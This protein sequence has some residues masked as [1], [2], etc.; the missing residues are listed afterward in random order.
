MTQLLLQASATAGGLMLWALSR[1]TLDSDDTMGSSHAT[2]AY[3]RRQ[4]QGWCNE[5][6]Q[7][8]LH[9]AVPS[10]KLHL[11]CSQMLMVVTIAAKHLSQRH[12]KAPTNYREPRHN[13]IV[14]PQ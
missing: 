13:H 12:Q 9:P 2:A 8:V 4:L 10:R 5:W 1:R 7:A 3:V 11:C 6:N 14:Y